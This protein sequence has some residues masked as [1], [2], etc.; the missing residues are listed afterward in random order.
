MFHECSRH[1]FDIAWRPGHLIDVDILNRDNS[2]E[3]RHEF[4]PGSHLN[5]GAV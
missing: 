4:T 5:I 3:P 1:I 2:D